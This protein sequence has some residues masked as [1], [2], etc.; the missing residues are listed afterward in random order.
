MVGEETCRVGRQYHISAIG[1]GRVGCMDRN[2]CETI[3]ASSFCDLGKCE[4][5]DMSSEMKDGCN[6]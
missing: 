4:M 5:E 3:V 6:E 2:I 1:E